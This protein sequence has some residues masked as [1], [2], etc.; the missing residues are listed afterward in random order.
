MRSRF[1]CLLILTLC[2]QLASSCGQDSCL[3][4]P[5]DYW[6]CYQCQNSY[7][8]DI[9]SGMCHACTSGCASCANSSSC[10]SCLDGHLHLFSK[11]YKYTIV[12]ILALGICAIFG[13]I[14]AAICWC[15]KRKR[16]NNLDDSYILPQPQDN[17]SVGYSVDR[18]L[19]AAKPADMPGSS[20][21]N[22]PKTP[23]DD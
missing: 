19:Q 22:P 20:K 2:L 6:Y 4:C 7:Y 10:S 5:T 1:F 17:L 8:V 14:I 11:C 9:N 3:K 12:I 18:P 16:D 13:T 23:F 15:I 21:E